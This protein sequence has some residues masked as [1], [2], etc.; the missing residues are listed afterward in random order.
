MGKAKRNKG[1]GLQK[2]T[3]G[4]KGGQ[5]K[6]ACFKGKTRRQSAALHIDAWSRIPGPK[7]EKKVGATNCGGRG[8][9]ARCV[10]GPEGKKGRGD[11]RHRGC[12]KGVQ[13]KSKKAHCEKGMSKNETLLE[14]R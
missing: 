13:E 5:K 8:Q 11:Q 10:V 6:G 4:K 1:L 14:K 3:P 12:G 7:V 9:S 2:K